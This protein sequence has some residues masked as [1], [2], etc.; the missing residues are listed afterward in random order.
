M[1]FPGGEPHVK[2]TPEVPG[3]KVVSVD[4]RLRDFEDVG[5]LMVL[6]DAL[7]RIGVDLDRLMVPYFPG[8]RQDRFQ[9]GPLTAAV[10]ADIFKGLGFNSIWTLDPHSSV[11]TALSGAYQMAAN[12]AEINGRGYDIVVAP[13]AG[14][15][16]R[17]A[18]FAR[19]YGIAETRQGLKHRDPKTGELSGFELL[20]DG[21]DGPCKIAVA[22]DICDGG[23]TFLPLA[24][25]ITKKFPKAYVDL[26]VTHGIFSKG[27]DVLFDKF[28]RIYSSTSF[29]SAEQLAEMGVTPLKLYREEN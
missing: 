17:T 6:V 4:A 5:Y 25:L 10:Y 11:C 26:V 7:G 1:T 24:D 13:D 22:D 16:H 12:W 8:S 29:H 27:T 28:D 14:A 21:Y 23:G 15:Q 19:E 2:L 20:G 3:M 18:E 9:G